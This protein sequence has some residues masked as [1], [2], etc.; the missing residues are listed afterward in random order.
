[1]ADGRKASFLIGSKQQERGIAVAKP[2]RCIG[3]G[4]KWLRCVLH[5]RREVLVGEFIKLHAFFSLGHEA[6]QEGPSKT[7]GGPPCGHG[8]LL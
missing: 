2:A 6:G 5:G 3:A 4:G 1:M 8:G 7:I